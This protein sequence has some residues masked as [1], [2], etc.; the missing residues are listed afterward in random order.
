MKGISPYLISVLLF[1]STFAACTSLSTGSAPKNQAA[2]TIPLLLARKVDPQKTSSSEM[3]QL[4]GKPDSIQIV[5]AG[6]REIWIY[7]R[8]VEPPT[9]RLYAFVNHNSGAI[10]SITWNAFEQDPESKLEYIKEELGNLNLTKS[11][12][13]WLKGDS[14]PDDVYFKNEE[15]RLTI[16]LRK[17]SN[18]VDRV[19]W[20]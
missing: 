6:T 12:P 7:L 16:V 1:L 13:K 8:S 14:A 5:E 11:E 17:T 2:K 15:Q 19:I 4:F 9:R 10:E 3:K 18:R 20:R